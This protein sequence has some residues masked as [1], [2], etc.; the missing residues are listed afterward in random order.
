[1]IEITPDKH[2]VRQAGATGRC[3]GGPEPLASPNGDTPLPNGHVLVSTI[4]DHR[5]TEL[6]EALRPIFKMTLPMRYPSDPQLTKA[7]NFLIADYTRPGK[8]IEITS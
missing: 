8:I 4:R 2:I 1:V 7:G 6:D 5:L 3:S